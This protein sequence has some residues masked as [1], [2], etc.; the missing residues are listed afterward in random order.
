[1]GQ[2]M[3]AAMQRVPEADANQP[4]KSAVCHGYAAGTGE[5]RA[6]QIRCGARLLP[7]L[8][9]LP[10]GAGAGSHRTTQR[11]GAADSSAERG[12]PLATR[13]ERMVGCSLPLDGGG[14][15]VYIL[16]RNR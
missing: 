2:A 16:P 5:L 6:R 13:A 9:T 11:H 10:D 8:R 12:A 15:L 3:S 14:L 1:M 7:G 4:H